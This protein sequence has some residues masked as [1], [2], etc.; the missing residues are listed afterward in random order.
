MKLLKN[1]ISVAMSNIVNFGTSFI[2]GFILPTILT[3]GDYGN[4]RTYTLYLSIVYL[5][6]FGFSDGIYI[7]Y[8]GLEESDLDHQEVHSEHTFSLIF[9]LLVFAIMLIISLIRQDIILVLFSIVTFFMTMNT[10]HQNFLQAIGQFKTYSFGSITKSVVYVLFLLFAVFILKSDNY[11]L[12]I[13]L[14]VLS[15]VVLFFFFEYHF[16]KEEGFHFNFDLAGKASLFRVGFLILIAN[17][18]LNF[19]GLIGNWVVKFGFENEVFAQYSFQNSILNVILLVVNAVGMVFYNLLSK[20]QN[21]KM[22]AMIKKMSMLIGIASGLAFF[23]FKIIIIFFINKYTPAIELLSITF[24]AIPYIIISKILVANL[25]K[26]QRSEKE[27]IRDSIAYAGLSLAFVSGVS[28]LTKSVPA[29]AWATTVCYLMWYL[30][31]SHKQFTFMRSNAK[32]FILI[33]SHMLIFYICANWL[34]TGIGLL[35]YL[36]YIVAIL[37][38]LRKELVHIIQQLKVS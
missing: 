7:K 10:Y 35:V 15:A 2:I 13:A 22:I 8:G 14:N 24:I 37:F 11:V 4:Y 32:E 12:Y 19:V 1:I 25:Y 36:V 21:K 26:T 31:A 9:Q 16:Y 23:I 38:A 29:I 34:S 18:S 27:Y 6:H 17:M 28:F 3:V 30:Y 5:F 20:N 33:G